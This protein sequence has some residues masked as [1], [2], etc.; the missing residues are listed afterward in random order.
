M[1][2]TSSQLAQ[3]LGVTKARVSQMVAQG[4]LDGCYSGDGRARR[5]D[6]AVVASTLGR[7][8]DPGQMMGN[9]AGTKRA[10]AELRDG[11]EAPKAAPA[12]PT[13]PMRDGPIET[14]DP[15]RYELARIQKAEEEAR[16]LRRQNAEAE[17]MYVLASEVE[18]QVGRVVAQEIAQFEQVLRQGARAVADRMGVDFKTA[19]QI[20][21]DTWRAHRSER[22]GVLIEAA[23]AE[24]L[25]EVEKAE[26]I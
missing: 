21:I 1:L 23:K 20:L 9:G 17:G 22:A 19:R 10:L 7:R 4:K 14:T 11:I 25:T 18:R 24:D 3:Q 8:L 15:D 6:L 5:F 12:T 13:R 2:V 26:D 16:R